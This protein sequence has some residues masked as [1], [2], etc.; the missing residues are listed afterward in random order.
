MLVKVK[1]GNKEAVNTL[2]LGHIGLAG[3]IAAR[4]AKDYPWKDS[5]D[6]AAYTLY[7]LVEQTNRIATGELMTHHDNYSAYIHYVLGKEV[8]RYLDQDHVI[9]PPTNDPKCLQEIRDNAEE[10]RDRYTPRQ[11]TEN[12]G[13]IPPANRDYD[14]VIKDLVIRS[15]FFTRQEQ[16]IIYLRLQGFDD[17]E[18][19]AVFG[20]TKQRIEQIRKG[21]RNR[22]E[23]VT[24][25]TAPC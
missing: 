13:T 10:F 12:H 21:L 2:I 23:L 18:I 22:L 17:I 8:K 3:A 9:Q 25:E 5:D 24:G 4:F 19:G 7:K 6:I 20:V 1:E 11:I 16:Q 15:K 14:L